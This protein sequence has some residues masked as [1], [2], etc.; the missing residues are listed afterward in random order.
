MIHFLDPLAR[1]IENNPADVTAYAC[2]AL[3]FGC[4]CWLLSTPD[5]LM[6]FGPILGALV[7]LGIRDGQYPGHTLP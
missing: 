2:A 3:A 6:G 4:G 1:Y 7:G 5:W